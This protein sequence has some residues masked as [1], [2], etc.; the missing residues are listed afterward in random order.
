MMIVARRHR[1]QKR[2]LQHEHKGYNR[3]MITH[4]QLRDYCLGKLGTTEAFPFDMNVRV[5]K[6]RGKMFALS[7]VND[8]PCEVNLKCDPDWA[9]M[10][11]QTYA[12]VAP[13]YHMNKRHWNTVTLDGTIPED[14]IWEMVDHSYRLVAQKLKKADREGLLLE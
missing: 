14:E 7:N 2:S 4:Q 9:E 8:D 3:R 5:F 12:A 1:L 11:R 13:G 10:L 6:V